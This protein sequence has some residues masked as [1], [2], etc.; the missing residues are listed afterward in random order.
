MPFD[1]HKR[2]D[3]FRIGDLVRVYGENKNIGIIISK[4]TYPYGSLEWEVIYPSGERARSQPQWIDLV[5]RN[6]K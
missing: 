5:L 2:L 6:P 1:F 3:D 4:V